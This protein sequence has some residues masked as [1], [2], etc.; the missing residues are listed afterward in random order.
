MAAKLKEY[1]NGIYGLKCGKH[2]IVPRASEENKFDVIDNNK[3]IVSQGYPDVD[4]A[5]W[6]IKYHELTPNKKEIFDKLAKMGMWEYGDIIGKFIRG[7]KIS[8][9]PADDEWL[10][11]TVIALQHRKKQ[12]KPEIPG[13]DTSYQKLRVEEK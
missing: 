8:G 9:N 10:Y 7:D 6:F 4:E 3:N 12:L 11:K 2:Y 5:Q 1:K 13:D